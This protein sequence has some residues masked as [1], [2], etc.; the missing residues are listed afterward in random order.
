MDWE[1]KIGDIC[2][3]AHAQLVKLGERSLFP[4]YKVVAVFE[5]KG[6]VKVDRLIPSDL[7]EAVLKAA[8]HSTLRNI[9]NG[10]IF[11]AIDNVI[12]DVYPTYDWQYEELESYVLNIETLK[13]AGRTY[14]KVL[15]EERVCA[16]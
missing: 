2:T 13:P 12:K 14:L 7:Y 1:P 9:E 11:K 4:L 6:Y 8:Q 5:E 15:N 16:A 3:L 10:D